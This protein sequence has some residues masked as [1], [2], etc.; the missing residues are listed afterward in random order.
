MSKKNGSGFSFGVALGALIGTGAM[1]LANTK[2]GKKYKKII[3]DH[4][5]KTAETLK[6]KYP[7]ES[8][9]VENILHQALAEAQKA[10]EEIK[11]L[12]HQATVKAKK[13]TLFMN[14]AIKAAKKQKKKRTF[15]K[16]GKPL[17][18]KNP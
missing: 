8:E 6:E 11:D 15:S 12:S 2:D 9:Q 13:K 3:K 17:K 7:E 14:K 18:K 4:F 5:E 16:S 1:I 10:T